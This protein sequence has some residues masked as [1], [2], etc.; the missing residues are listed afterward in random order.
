[1]LPVSKGHPKQISRAADLLLGAEKPIIYS[2]GG[3]IQGNAADELTQLVRE[4][5]FPCTNTAHGVRG[6]SVQRS[7]LPRH[8]RYAWHL[9]SQYG[10]V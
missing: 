4:L 8:A 5:A 9:R 7:A 2:G 10:D 6:V 3:I 1:M